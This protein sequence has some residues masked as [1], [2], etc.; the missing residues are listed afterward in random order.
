MFI[1]VLNNSQKIR[2]IKQES[3]RYNKQNNS[4][5][6]SQ[7]RGSHQHKEKTKKPDNKSS[8]KTKTQNVKLS[9]KKIITCKKDRRTIQEI[10]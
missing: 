10:Y 9:T 5:N 1:D 6:T 3:N 2:V 8:I 7:D 4:N